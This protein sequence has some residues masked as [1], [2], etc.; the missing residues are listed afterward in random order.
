[1]TTERIPRSR[2]R[3]ALPKVDYLERVD[4]ER[5]KEIDVF[6]ERVGVRVK[7]YDL[8]NRAFSHKSY[9]NEAGWSHNEQSEKLEFFGDGVLGLI[10]NEYLFKVFPEFEEGELAKIKSVVV[11][12]ASLAEVAREISLADVILVGRS[13]VKSGGAERSSLLSDILEAF[14]GAIYIDQGLPTARKFILRYFESSIRNYSTEES[15][16]DYK[17]YL[18]E[19]I[20]REYGVRPEYRVVRSSGPDHSRT[21]RVTVHFHGRKWGAGAGKSKKEAEQAAAEDGFN[22]WKNDRESRPRNEERNSSERRPERAERPRRPRREPRRAES[23]DEHAPSRPP[24]GERSPDRGYRGGG[25]RGFHREPKRR[26]DD[27]HEVPPSDIDD[28][29]A[30]AAGESYV[31]RRQR[32]ER[33]ERPDKEPAEGGRQGAQD[34]QESRGR[35]SRGRRRRRRGTSAGEHNAPPANSE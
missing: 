29:V 6:L 5:K 3:T 13:E 16:G 20:Q 26:D 21:F 15:V 4:E 17:S 14:I 33:P 22:Q 25:D 19:T 27:F 10:I 32:P 18:Q 28:P 9:T 24:R 31:P 23:R 30:W 2:Q 12:E 8:V 11:S 1:M 35:R 34:R 7:N